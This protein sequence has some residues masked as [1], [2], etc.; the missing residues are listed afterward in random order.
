MNPSKVKKNWLKIRGGGR[1]LIPFIVWSII[2]TIKNAIFGS[3]SLKNLFF[4]FLTGKSAAPLYYILVLLQLT[5]LTPYL[6]SRRKSWMYLITSVYLV[7]LYIFNITTGNMPMF[8]E[9]VFP[10]WFIFYILGMDVREGKLNSIKVKGWMI[11]LVL[12]ASFGESYLLMKIGCSLGFACSQIKFSS[13]AY[14]ILIALWLSQHIKETEPNIL[15]SIGDCSFGIYFS[16]ILVIWGVS[17]G[18]SIVGIDIWILKWIFIFL[19]TAILSYAFVWCVRRVFKG[20][21]IISY[22]GFE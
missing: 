9:T 8:Y 21:K 5:V 22:I 13:F 14:S 17:K 18:I 2:Y 3:P 1:L 6:I 15:S 11:G 16:H 10:A 19:L 12:L 20:K 7:F 4:A